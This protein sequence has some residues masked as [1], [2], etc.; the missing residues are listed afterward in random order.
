MGTRT[1]RAAHL[2]NHGWCQRHPGRTRSRPPLDCALHV[3]A[4]R[5][6]Q[7]RTARSVRYYITNLL[8][9]T[10]AALRKIVAHN[11]ARLE[12]IMAL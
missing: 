12:P 10:G 11:S 2:Y 3:A 7:G 4:E 1:H 5:T 8:V 6:V 9:E